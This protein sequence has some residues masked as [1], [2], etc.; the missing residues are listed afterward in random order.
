MTILSVRHVTIYR[1]KQPVAF[2]EHRM[3]F[4]PR[5]SYDQR[6]IEASL[7][8]QPEPAH[9]RWIHDA[10]GNCVA[11]ASF[12]GQASELRIESNIRLDHAPTNAPDFQIEEFARNY[13]FS[14]APD[15]LPDLLASMERRYPDPEREL[16]RWARKFLRQGH[17]TGTGELLKTLTYGI[18]ESFA[19]ARRSEGGTYP[20]LTTLHLGRGSCRDL[21][22]LMIE[23]VRCL[24]LAARFVSGYI[25]VPDR[26]EPSHLGGG[27]T[28]AWCQVYLPGA[29][30]VELDP[31][32]GIVGNRDLIRVAVARDPAQAI[33]LTGTFFGDAD[34][35][36]GM[37]VEVQVTTAEPH[38]EPTSGAAHARWEETNENSRRI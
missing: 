14:Y 18:K 16:E 5:D 36:L 4:R 29:G 23:A 21:A 15:E 34:D 27:S 12:T 24:G 35:E 7:T 19:Y 31:T 20:P 22:L 9:I 10:F 30:W 6:L 38:T 25:Y 2:G 11:I 1:Y 28:H 37:S 26:D 3:M 13:P 32:N 17:T 33:P 8:I